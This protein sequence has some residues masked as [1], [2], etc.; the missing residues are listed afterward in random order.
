MLRMSAARNAASPYLIDFPTK[1][2]KAW[3]G[4]ILQNMEGHARVSHRAK[5]PREAT[6][7]NGNGNENKF[8]HWF[9]LMSA[10]LQ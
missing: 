1:D 9:D 7:A 2:A 4:A 5:G 10:G 8:R 6:S 3:P